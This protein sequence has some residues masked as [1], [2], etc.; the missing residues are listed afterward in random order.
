VDDEGTAGAHHGQGGG[1]QG[2]IHRRWGHTLYVLGHVF[3]S[4][5]DPDPE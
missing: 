3:S 5:V 1:C 4:V 2:L